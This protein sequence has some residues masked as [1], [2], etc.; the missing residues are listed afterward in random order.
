MST[1]KM[2]GAAAAALLIAAPAT[3]GVMSAKNDKAGKGHLA[4]MMKLEMGKPGDL[5][6]RARN[7]DKPL[8]AASAG[9]VAV[10]TSVTV[11]PEGKAVHRV[12]TNGPVPDTPENR[13]AYGGPMSRAGERT[14]PV[15]N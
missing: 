8:V 1:V 7:R 11:G 9:D 12:I 13:D 4:V 10:D 5:K 6:A 2:L 3:A 15:G 14:A